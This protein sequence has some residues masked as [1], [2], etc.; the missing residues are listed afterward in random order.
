MLHVGLQQNIRLAVGCPIRGPRR[1]LFPKIER[2]VRP[3]R[4]RE[5]LDDGTESRVALNQQDIAGLE[6]ALKASAGG[7]KK[8]A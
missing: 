1:L 4:L 2:G 5:K 7:E 8:G 3:G 6:R